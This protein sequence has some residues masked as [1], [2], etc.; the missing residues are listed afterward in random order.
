MSSVAVA[1]PQTL[2]PGYGLS[3]RVLVNVLTRPVRAAARHPRRLGVIL[4]VA[5]ICVAAAWRS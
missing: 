4:L 1:A 5:A 2:Q 3:P